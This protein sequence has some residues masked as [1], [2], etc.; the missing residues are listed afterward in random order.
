MNGLARDILLGFRRLARTPGQTLAAVAAL[1][2]GI[3]LSTAAFS[4]TWGIVVRGL[5]VEKPGQILHLESDNP[6][7]NQ[8]SLG[9][10]LQDFLEWRRRQ[11]S[12]EGLAAYQLQT[13]N[14]SGDRQ[15]ERVEGARL[16]ADAFDLLRVRPALGRGFRAGEDSPQAERVVVLGWD[17][18][19]ARYGGDPEVIGRAVRVNG[20]PAT[21]V[22]V[23]P[24]GFGF[25]LHQQVWEPMRLDPGR[26]PRGSG[27]TVEVFGRLRDGVTAER[28]RAEMSGIARALAAELPATN[29]GRGAVVRPYTE[30]YLGDGPA[31]V[32]HAML[33]ACLLVLVLGCTN[34]AALGSARA[35]Q[36]TREM[37]VRT[38]LGAS[39]G[40]LL[41]L[42]LVESFLTAALGTLLAIP[43]AAAGVRTFNSL[44]AERGVPFWVEVDL[45][46]R[47]LLFAAGL[48]LAAGLASGLVP[49][50]Q[51]ARAGLADVLKDEGRSTGRRQGWTLRAIVVL[52]VAVSCALLVSAGLM[53]Q[54]VRHVSTRT[55]FRTA[56]LF[57]ARLALSEDRYAANAARVRFV[58]ELLRRLRED[59]AV[60]AAAAGSYLP[61]TGSATSACAVEGEAYA[62]ERDYPVAHNASVSADFFERFGAGVLR[63]RGFASMDTPASLPVVVVNE[64][65]ARQ[66]WPR[67]N[68]LGRRIRIALGRPDEPWRTVVGV[69]PD[70]A[71]EH[72]AISDDGA[73][74]Y[75]PLSQEAPAVLSLVIETR[76]PDPLT[77]TR[78]VRGHVAAVDRDLPIYYVYS[79]A[80]AVEI[81]GFFPRFFAASFSIFGLAALLLA[82]VGIYGVLALAVARRT[83]EIGI[84][85][86]LGA[87]PGSVLVLVLRQGLAELFFGLALGLLLAWPAAKMLG[88]LLVGVD[89]QDPPT[90]LGVALVL[91]A[92][93][94]LA[95][96][97]PARRASRTDPVAAIRYD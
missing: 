71:M 18:W 9:V 1:T 57:T 32:L 35:A 77:V 30:K 40:R 97:F 49:A 38:A 64:S 19:Q 24:E 87:R 84:R 85:M 52:E 42:L 83:P 41:R 95:C 7:Q 54:N 67:Q 69:V 5:P 58:E 62:A 14:L 17:L 91:A 11:T 20:A 48:T 90:F 22:G 96:W 56:R 39:R 46:R 13:A 82:S 6:P 94:L 36:R 15:A 72:V 59:P 78:R 55:G 70:L 93:S 2:L 60:L 88:S 43:L 61:A 4:M 44:I 45:D 47:A 86:A 16:S 63:G 66:R 8:P 27:P 73:G 92:V 74:F 81:V 34:V 50:L 33:G 75:L 21:V 65:F 53:I 79:M 3:G 12:F 68:P 37:A 29:R 76:D 31:Q 10:Y 28:A 80:R 23:M 25:P 89:P 51:A 26:S